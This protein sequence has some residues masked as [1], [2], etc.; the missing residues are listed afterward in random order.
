MS[1]YTPGPWKF[2]P[3]KDDWCIRSERFI[4]SNLMGSCY[5]NIIADLS[6]SHGHREHVKKEAKANGKLI[7]AAPDLLDALEGLIDFCDGLD[8][9]HGIDDYFLGGDD[10]YQN[11][12]TILNKAIKARDKSKGDTN[13]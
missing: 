12:K 9:Q 6:P 13:D 10:F 1:E 8:S 4:E 3:K 5:G 2:N 7:A 11:Y